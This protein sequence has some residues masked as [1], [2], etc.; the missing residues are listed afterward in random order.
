M[1]PW[2][3][4]I[5]RHPAS[6]CNYLL[7]P[8]T[9]T[10]NSNYSGANVIEKLLKNKFQKTTEKESWLYFSFGKAKFVYWY[11]LSSNI[12]G[13]KGMTGLKNS[14][15]AKMSSPLGPPELCWDHFVNILVSTWLNRPSRLK[16][17]WVQC[18]A[19]SPHNLPKM[20]C[21][22]WERHKWFIKE[23]TDTV[24]RNMT[25]LEFCTRGNIAAQLGGV[26]STRILILWEAYLTSLKL[27][28]IQRAPHQPHTP[29]PLYGP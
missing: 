18:L 6:L 8:Y 10:T 15:V 16:L 1:F 28:H 27:C 26:L 21:I 17:C 5:S 23:R 20:I 24:R 12:S 14:K 19:F 22:Q 2:G 13:P 25:I 9:C 7:S 11:L 4:R 29:L 3:G